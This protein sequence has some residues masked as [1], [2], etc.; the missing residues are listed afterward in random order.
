ME[1]RNDNFSIRLLVPSFLKKIFRE[2]SS[3]NER[4][5]RDNDQEKELP[6]VL[7][8]N[9]LT[10]K[11]HNLNEHCPIKYISKSILTH[12]TTQTEAVHYWIASLVKLVQFGK[13]L[14]KVSY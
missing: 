10:M 12:D 1:K 7:K 3:F 13:A 8:C 4:R 5:G 11:N 6:K 2:I 9:C 14:K